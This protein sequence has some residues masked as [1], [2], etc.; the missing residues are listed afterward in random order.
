MK[1]SGI[2]HITPFAAVLASAG[3]MAALI[4]A[5]ILVSC[6]P[7]AP[8]GRTATPTISGLANPASV[9]C[10]EK[11][12][13]LEIRSDTDGGQYGVCIFPDGTECEE[14]AFYRNQCAPGTPAPAPAPKQ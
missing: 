5:T 7:A 12:N 14:W 1:R 10:T 11:G 9:F 2:L 3:L 4:L 6:A 13:K 8:A